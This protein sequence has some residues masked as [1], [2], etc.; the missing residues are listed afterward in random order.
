MRR[1]GRNHV[2]GSLVLHDSLMNLING[3]FPV[4]GKLRV[5]HIA[6]N[7][8]GAVL[9]RLLR[10]LLLL[11]LWRWI[12]RC[13]KATEC[14]WRGCRAT[15]ASK[16]RRSGSSKTTKG[17]RSGSSKVPES[18]RSRR[19]SGTKASKCRRSRS[20][21]AK[22]AWGCRSGRPKGRGSSRTKGKCH[23]QTMGDRGVFL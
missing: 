15:K 16:R 13:S 2:H 21:R 7:I 14:G 10:L 6:S 18:G 20:R 12:L 4:I 8:C 5:K 11:L 9:R 1:H 3:S 22:G 19:R 17:G 23:D